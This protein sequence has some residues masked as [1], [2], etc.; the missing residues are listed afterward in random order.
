MTARLATQ[1]LVPL[2]RQ[3]SE[4]LSKMI[5]RG[6]FISGAALP[7]ESSLC[8]QF[9]VSRITI[10]KALDE[11][12]T[13]GLVTRRRGVGT[14]VSEPDRIAWSVTL[15]GIIEDVISPTR[16]KIHGE[17]VAVP[18][19][20]VLRFAG[21][22]GG[23]RLKRFEGTNYADGRTPLLHAYYYFPE[24]VA[25]HLSAEALTGAVQAIIYVQQRIGILV[26]HAEQVVQPTNASTIVA[27]RLHL[28]TGT[29]VL[30]ATRVYYDADQR[31]VEIFEAFYHPVHYRYTATLYP[32]GNR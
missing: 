6:E 17:K 21:L 25:K 23:T 28:P 10:R 22:P 32:R 24:H 11:L 19:A 2:Y 5:L 12:V 9:A 15:T 16:M 1:E 27:S 7:S 18:P 4:H 20:D 3:V 13:Q 8:S 30:R 29:A 14:F 26:D 31:P